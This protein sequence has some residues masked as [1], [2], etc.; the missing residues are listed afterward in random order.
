MSK[1]LLFLLLLTFATISTTHAAEALHE[2]DRCELSTGETQGQDALGLAVTTSSEQA[3]SESMSCHDGIPKIAEGYEDVYRRFLKGKLV[4][5]PD[6][7]S[8]LGK[9]ELPIA[10]LDTP[11]EG[12]FDLSGCGESSEYLHIST[13]FRTRVDSGNREK[14]EVWI[15]PQFVLQKDPRA[16]ALNDILQ[17]LPEHRNKAF[18]VM[19]NLGE[20]ENLSWHEIT[21]LNDRTYDTLY[22]CYA[23]AKEWPTDRRQ[24]IVYAREYREK[25]NKFQYI[26]ESTTESELEKFRAAEQRV[27]AA[28]EHSREQ[29][30]NQDAQSLMVLETVPKLQPSMSGEAVIPE[31]AKGFEDVYRQ[32]LKGK[33]VYKPNKDNDDGR[34]DFPIAS[35]AN[36]LEGTFDISRCAEFGQE[37]EV[38]T[39]F[40]TNV[41]PANKSK[42][43]VWIVPQFVLQSDPRAKSINDSLQSNEKHRGKPFAILFTWGGW[44]DLSWHEVTGIVGD[45]FDT[46]FQVWRKAPTSADAHMPSGDGWS[47]PR[48]LTPM[49]PAWPCLENF[50][51]IMSD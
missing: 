43:E 36:P 17:T 3:L 34:I 20:W 19:F 50:M 23:C 42:L 24:W 29:Q 15:V 2:K 37:I 38:S 30:L 51:V 31:I 1:K 28:E 25:L 39:G 46:L 4:Y 41:N 21:G 22:A 40:R 16:K 8:D 48:T 35:L 11:L 9:I 47:V 33:L 26:N 27:Q 13:G 5:T 49:A 10:A 12:T 45:E 32:F 7:T 6:P 18:A 44:K 14:I